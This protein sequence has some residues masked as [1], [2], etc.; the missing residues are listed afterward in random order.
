MMAYVIKLFINY[1]CFTLIKKRKE[2]IPIL[3]AKIFPSSAG[4]YSTFFLDFIKSKIFYIV[5]LSYKTL[6][7]LLIIGEIKSNT[8]PQSSNMNLN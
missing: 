3:T 8:G 6:I 1:L 2:E 4:F 7:Y 5:W